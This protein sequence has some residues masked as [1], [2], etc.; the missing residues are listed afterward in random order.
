MITVTLFGKPSYPF[1]Y[2]KSVV[3]DKLEKAKVHYKIIE[4]TELSDFMNQNIDQIPALQFENQ[5]MY[6]DKTHSK[7]SIQRMTKTILKNENF[8]KMTKIISPVDYS[9]NS[10]N[11]FEYAFELGQDLGAVNKLI[12]VYRPSATAIDEHVSVYV[13]ME[14]AENRKF[15]KYVS[16]I[17]QDKTT[18]LG[19]DQILD[20]EF[21][22]GL[23][24]DTI[25]EYSNA[26]NHLIVMGTKGNTGIAKRWFG[27]VSTKVAKSA[28]CPVLVV[29][30]QAKYSGIENILYLADELDLDGGI[31]EI[32]K[33]TFK[34]KRPNIH[35][36]HIDDGEYYDFEKLK[37]VWSKFYSS[38]KLKYQLLKDISTAALEEYI[39]KNSIGLIVLNRRQRSFMENIFHESMTKKLV[40]HSKTPL[41]IYHANDQK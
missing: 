24:G 34:E 19:K 6:L 38:E 36:V 33:K 27:S 23:P 41:L 8:G 21:L 26:P 16:S 11:A 14:K 4:K 12:H 37:S 25:I 29:P 7:S 30:P 31:V 5:I 17:F 15:K 28:Q 20:S 35:A 18:K 39:E 9:E 3:K 10:K 1:H 22:I 40:L 32:V 13:E 2:L